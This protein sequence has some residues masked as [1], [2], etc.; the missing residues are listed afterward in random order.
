MSTTLQRT[1]TT[2]YGAAATSDGTTK[3]HLNERGSAATHRFQIV[4]WVGVAAVGLSLWTILEQNERSV[5]ATLL[6]LIG[7]STVAWSVGL[8]SSGRPGNAD[9]NRVE[10]YSLIGMGALVA[11]AVVTGTITSPFILLLPLG[12]GLLSARKTNPRFAIAG[13][14]LGLAGLL[15]VGVRMFISSDS[16]ERSSILFLSSIGLMTLFAYFAAARLG[17]ASKV[18]SAPRERSDSQSGLNRDQIERLDSANSPIAVARV[19]ADILHES[20]KPTYLAI[21]EQIPETKILRPLVERGTLDID[22]ERLRT[23]LATL[24]H[25]SVSATEARILLNDGSNLD[26]VVCRRLGVDAVLIVPLRRMGAGIGAIHMAWSELNAQHQLVMARELA[27]N[28]S[29]WITPDIAISRVA[30]ELERGYVNAIAGVCS[31]LDERSEFTAGHG[32]RV[33]RIALEVAELLPLSDHDQRQL[34]YAAEMH[35]LGWVGVDH[36]L[37]KKPAALNDEEW[38]RVQTIPGRG[39]GIVDTVSYFGEVSDAIRYVRERWD[40]NGYPRGLKGEDIPL[41]ARIIAISEA[42]D[43]MTSP[44]PYR[45]AMTPNDALRQL[46]RER[47]AKFDPQIV[48]AFVMHRAP[49]RESVN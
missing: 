38:T 15:G 29:H 31:S 41:L 8:W 16:I 46:W 6:A 1:T 48:E 2:N 17:P 47:G 13:G 39:A 11:A 23:G 21:V 49:V 19:A 37:L 25:E 4:L 3:R 32:R 10:I 7:V 43:S 26:S 36:E 12:V 40:G 18:N 45:A 28:I 9:L 44:R 33:A 27:M 22:L 34:V 35:D 24:S 5:I 14:A 30:S 20:T 42:Y